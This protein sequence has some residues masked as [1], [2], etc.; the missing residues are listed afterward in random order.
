MFGAIWRKKLILARNPSIG[1][2][3]DY[4][5][6]REIQVKHNEF[7]VSPI[8]RPCLGEI[9][10]LVAVHIAPADDRLHFRTAATALDLGPHDGLQ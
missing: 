4:W 5:G 1:S 8:I 6:E 2:I 9:A 3:H 10:M 7:S